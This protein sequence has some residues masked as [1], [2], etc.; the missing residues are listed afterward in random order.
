MAV[1]PLNDEFSS[2]AHRDSQEGKPRFDLIDAGWIIAVWENWEALDSARPTKRDVYEAFTNRQLLGAA[3]HLLQH[4]YPNTDECDR[5][6]FS[7]Y[8]TVYITG[9]RGLVISSD[10]PYKGLE[11]LAML[12]HRGA[13]KYGANNW[14]R[15]MPLWRT[16]ASL[17][18]HFW[19]WDDGD[20]NEDHFAAI[21]FNL[22]VLFY[23]KNGI[24]SGLLDE[25]LA[26]AE[27]DTQDTP[28][29]TRADNYSRKAYAAY[30]GV[31]TD[32]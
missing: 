24:A 23:T 20:T 5:L 12:L 17:H 29:P 9:V 3:C 16:R 30:Y 13:I 22:M 1:I 15:G 28:T 6:L 32:D 10:M 7:G 19:A 31:N 11:R 2:G 14:R 26:L 21:L 25:S 4:E 8:S 18:R 27:D